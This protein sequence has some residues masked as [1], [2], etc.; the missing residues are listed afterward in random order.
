VALVLALAAPTAPLHAEGDAPASAP[1]A[2]S[3]SA[4]AAPAPLPSPPTGPISARTRLAAIFQ[5]R[6]TAAPGGFAAVKVLPAPDR[7][8][9]LACIAKAL[10]ADIPEADAARLADMLEQKTPPDA[11]L[12][13]RWL[14]TEK[15]ENPTRH[16]EVAA[17]TAEL[18]PDLA[19]RL[20]KGG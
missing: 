8:R 2:A 17:R 16:A 6:L 4:P 12:V 11:D 20:N 15:T 14:I 18:C 3:P 19:G 9:G 13:R 10:A 5:A 7:P 1:A